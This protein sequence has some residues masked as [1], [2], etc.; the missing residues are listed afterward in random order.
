M[1]SSEARTRIPGM[2]ATA[3]YMGLRGGAARAGVTRGASD[4]RLR[5]MEKAA[6]GVGVG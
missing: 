6:K 1:A 2:R 5:E 3:P 4:R